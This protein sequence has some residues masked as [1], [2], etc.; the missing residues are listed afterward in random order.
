MYIHTICIFNIEL[1]IVCRVVKRL[2]HASAFL[3]DK[4]LGTRQWHA[5]FALFK[6]RDFMRQVRLKSEVFI[7]IFKIMNVYLN[8]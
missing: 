8:C 6:L 1:S 5:M 7:I 4:D 2:E 3:E